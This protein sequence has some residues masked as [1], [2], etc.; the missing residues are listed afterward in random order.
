M[1]ISDEHGTE[2][3]DFL[4]SGRRLAADDGE[5]GLGQNRGD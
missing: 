2:T 3:T 4:T 1:L 5:R